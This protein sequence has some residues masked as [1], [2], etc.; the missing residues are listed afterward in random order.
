MRATLVSF[1]LLL[2]AITACSKATP[3]TPANT[4]LV[5]D[6]HTP[7]TFVYSYATT[8]VGTHVMSSKEPVPG[9]VSRGN[10]TLK[11]IAKGGRATVDIDSVVSDGIETEHTQEQ[12]IEGMREN[13]DASSGDQFQQEIMLPLP[14]TDLKEGESG[15]VKFIVE[16]SFNG[17]THGLKVV[18]TL[19]HVGFTTIAGRECAKLE[20]KISGPRKIH[21]IDGAQ[22]S[23]AMGGTANYCFDVVNH[24]YVSADT[25]YWL[26]AQ[27]KLSD[28]TFL[29]GLDIASASAMR[30]QTVEP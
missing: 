14:T 19:T 17:K 3:P 29:M 27:S 4:E 23:F 18:N 2:F 5:W 12:L 13:G 30:L 6:F 15:Q 28:G 20:G 22:M 11:I 9:E 24:N 21:R 7:R 1:G 25:S 10:G 8:F 26:R 16:T